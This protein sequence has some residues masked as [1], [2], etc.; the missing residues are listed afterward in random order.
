MY[1]FISV[2]HCNV[3]VTASIT[4]DLLSVGMFDAHKIVQ[5]LIMA[6]GKGTLLH[7]QYGTD[8]N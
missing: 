1:G 5:L 3:V 2:P 7:T 8:V 6:E 4:L